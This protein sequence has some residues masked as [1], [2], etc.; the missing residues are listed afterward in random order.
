[1][2]ADSH[3]AAGEKISIFTSIFP[4]TGV[5]EIERMQSV[6]CIIKSQFINKLSGNYT[7]FG[8]PS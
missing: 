6:S 3:Y 2:I 8:L 5:T 1:M 7:T 4:S